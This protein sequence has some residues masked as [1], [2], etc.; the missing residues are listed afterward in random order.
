M[1]WKCKAIKIKYIQQ[2]E[3]SPQYYMSHKIRRTFC[4]IH[5]TT[6]IARFCYKFICKYS[7][8]LKQGFQYKQHVLNI[9]FSV[10]Y[11]YLTSSRDETRYRIQ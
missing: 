11:F 9:N 6:F 5:C 10:T 2:A 8:S 3:V 7:K 4:T 1:V